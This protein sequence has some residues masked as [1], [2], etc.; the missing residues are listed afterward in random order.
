MTPTVRDGLTPLI[1][2]FLFNFVFVFVQ[3]VITSLWCVITTKLF[4]SVSQHCH[5][6]KNFPKQLL[7]LFDGDL[8]LLLYLYEYYDHTLEDMYISEY[9]NRL[10]TYEMK[11][12][13]RPLLLCVRYHCYAYPP[14]LTV[15]HSQPATQKWKMS[16]VHS[17]EGA[18][19]FHNLGF[20]LTFWCFFLPRV[21]FMSQVFWGLLWQ[22]DLL[23]SGMGVR[24][25]LASQNAL[26]VMG[27]S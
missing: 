19:I 1:C 24:W 22:E 9:Q 13:C 6:N 18:R 12:N 20:G 17:S 2:T 14:I 4:S 23:I 26:E 8:L 21:Y 10:T 5:N 11:E 27:V 3:A 7:V 16:V 25:F 15:P